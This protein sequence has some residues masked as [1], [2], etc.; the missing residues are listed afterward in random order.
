MSDFDNNLFFEHKLNHEFPIIEKSYR[1]ERFGALP[2][3]SAEKLSDHYDEFLSLC[4]TT[5]LDY[6]SIEK[7]IEKSH[8]LNQEQLLKALDYTLNCYEVEAVNCI[9]I[10]IFS[11]DY[12]L[13]SEH[14][15]RAMKF[16]T[17]EISTYAVQ[18]CDG[19]VLS[20]VSEAINSRTTMAGTASYA[21]LIAIYEWKNRG[22][23]GELPNEA[24]MAYAALVRSCSN[25]H[26]E[27]LTLRCIPTICFDKRLNLIWKN[28]E[29]RNLIEEVFHDGNPTLELFYGV[30]FEELL[31]NLG[32]IPKH[33]KTQNRV[34]VKKS[35]QC[36]CGSKKKYVKCC[37]KT[38][39]NK[40]TPRPG[41][42]F[43]P[44]TTIGAL[45]P[46]FKKASLPNESIETKFEEAWIESLLMDN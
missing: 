43:D 38:D 11:C 16:L 22:G 24:I 3:L 21:L 36:P 12:R 13:S 32:V 7:L 33:L 20:A 27:D 41:E 9:I 10:V 35:A 40:T 8:P 42:S 6:T 23:E 5:T 37:Y 14:L 18:K 34:H 1:E 44:L 26:L 19:N 39:L 30:S 4:W 17:P 45:E 28:D 2:T 25:D 46:I 31:R 15:S 29:V